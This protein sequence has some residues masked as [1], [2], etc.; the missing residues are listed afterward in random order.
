MNAL[1][2]WLSRREVADYLSCSVDSVDRRLKPLAEGPERGKL[3][4]TRIEDWGTEREPVRILAED[5]YALLP[6]PAGHEEAAA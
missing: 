1:K 6:L 2:P 5:V 4:F 3:R